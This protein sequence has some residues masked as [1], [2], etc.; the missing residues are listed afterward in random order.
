MKPFLSIVERGGRVLL[1]KRAVACGAGP[2]SMA[3]RLLQNEAR[4]LGLL[5]GLNVPECIRFAQEADTVVLSRAFVAGPRL[6]ELPHRLW[7]DLLR[8][9]LGSLGEIHGR[10]LIHGDLKPANLIARDAGL[11]PIDWE[12]ALPVG[13]PIDAQP[14]RA[15]SPGTSDPRLI[16]GQ[17]VVLPDLDHHA[18]AAMRAQAGA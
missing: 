17:G 13:E 10:G 18:I 16:W 5:R 3:L 14:F 15:V 4:A 2:P 9:L 7:P 1:E 6:D 8:R 12:H 11:M